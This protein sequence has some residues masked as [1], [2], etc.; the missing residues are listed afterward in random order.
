MNESGKYPDTL[1][2]FASVNQKK[3]DE[4]NN[5]SMDELKNIADEK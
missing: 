1:E 3:V 5:Y 4:G 2:E